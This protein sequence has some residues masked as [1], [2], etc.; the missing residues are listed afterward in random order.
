MSQTHNQCLVTDSPAAGVPRP[1]PAGAVRDGAEPG[2]GGLPATPGTHSA[3][4]VPLT[5]EPSGVGFS[6]M[7]VGFFLGILQRG[8]SLQLGGER[9]A[10]SRF[11][12]GFCPESG[13]LCQPH[14][15]GTLRPT[16]AGNQLR[17]L[18]GPG[19]SRLS[20][21]VPWAP[22]AP[23]RTPHSLARDAA[24]EKVRPL[25]P[26]HSEPRRTD[27]PVGLEGGGGAGNETSPAPTGL[28]RFPHTRLTPP[29]SF[30]REPMGTKL[31]GR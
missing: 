14:A 11:L 4:L 25:P 21:R 16:H 13:W 10:A 27:V 2:G 29:P 30:R 23:L 22:A 17:A 6:W 20:A 26:P 9:A 8:S 15:P 5:A 19:L 1:P 31:S 3:E 18:G 28:L 24:P 12:P 7:G